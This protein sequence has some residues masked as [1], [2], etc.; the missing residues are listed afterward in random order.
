MVI[1]QLI[2]FIKKLLNEDFFIINLYS[3]ETQ[4]ALVSL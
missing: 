2:Y 1:Y 4:F 3:I